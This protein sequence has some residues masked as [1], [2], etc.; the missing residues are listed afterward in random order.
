[1]FT[2]FQVDD[3]DFLNQI[4][5]DPEKVNLSQLWW[6]HVNCIFMFFMVDVLVS[7]WNIS[8]WLMIS[9]QNQM[10]MESENLIQFVLLL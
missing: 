8:N 10:N 7:W 9:V 4:G 1:M 6:T 3:L 5:V 2:L